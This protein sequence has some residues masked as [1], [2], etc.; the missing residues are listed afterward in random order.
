M[1]LR[2][3]INYRRIIHILILLTATALCVGCGSKRKVTQSS[4]KETAER[5]EETLKK[6]TRSGVQQETVARQETQNRGVTLTE[7]EVYDTE[8]PADPA[9]GMRP[10]R[11]RV[12]QRHGEERLSHAAAQEIVSGETEIKAESLSTAGR[13]ELD[14]SSSAMTKAPD[15]SARMIL[16]FISVAG[17]VSLFIAAWVFYRFRKRWRQI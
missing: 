6:D 11:A 13:K 8:K 15:T 7:I 1:K 9:T 4:R 16:W 3:Q 12:R 10:V 5:V 14:E 17:L 2:K